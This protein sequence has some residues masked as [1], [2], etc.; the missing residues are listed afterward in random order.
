MGCQSRKLIPRAVVRLGIRGYVRRLWRWSYAMRPF[1]DHPQLR[2]H[3][4]HGIFWNV[5]HYLLLRA[6]AAVLL[7]R[8]RWA[9]PL[10]YWLARWYVAYQLAE[11]RAHA[12][13][14]ASMCGCRCWKR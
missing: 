3:L 2:A 6:L 13:A 8:R 11:S 12:P 4:H 9:W 5:S 7:A 14:R 10:A 1:A